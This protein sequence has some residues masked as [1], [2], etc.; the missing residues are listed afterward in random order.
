M[1][2]HLI[3]L[4]ARF[5]SRAHTAARIASAAV[6]L[7]GALA[8]AGWIFDSAVLKGQSAGITMKANTA[9]AFLL[10]G[11]SLWLVRRQA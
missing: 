4:N 6:M 5:V 2:D 7:A 1:S 10:S 9:L 8:L 3:R 11:A